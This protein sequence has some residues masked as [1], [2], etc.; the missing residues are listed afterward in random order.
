MTAAEKST[1]SREESDVGPIVAENLARVREQIG[2]AAERAG[3]SPDG[4]TLV[5]VSKYVD[6]AATRALAD[7]GCVD[8]G[9]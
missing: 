6:A 3:R 9:E 8:L 2:A 4:V 1:A 7:A 5:G